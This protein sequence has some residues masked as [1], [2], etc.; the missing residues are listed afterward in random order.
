MS[1]YLRSRFSII[2]APIADGGSAAVLT[3]EI[4]RRFGEGIK[5]VI[6][7]MKRVMIKLNIK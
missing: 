1:C 7:E 5:E 2:Q 4:V 6:G 3:G